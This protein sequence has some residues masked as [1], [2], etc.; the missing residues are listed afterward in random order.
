MY[1]HIYIFWVIVSQEVFFVFFCTRFYRMQL[2]F[3]QIDLTNR[4]QT[5][6]ASPNQN[7]SERNDNEEILHNPQISKNWILSIWY[8]LVSYPGHPFL[9]V[10]Y[11]S[12]GGYN[13]CILSLTDRVM[14]I[15][16]FMCPFVMGKEQ[17][18]LL[19]IFLM[20]YNNVKCASLSNKYWRE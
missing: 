9:E 13:Q 4:T 2:I 1:I 6:I 12:V 15:L 14:K 11:L 10:S 7:E 5:D 16:Q 17:I 18:L 20:L 3:K 19:M 8:S